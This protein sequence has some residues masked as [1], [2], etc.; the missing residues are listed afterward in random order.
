[1]LLVEDNPSI[2]QFMAMVVETHPIDL[3]LAGTLAE[4]GAALV[5]RAYDLVVTDL[6]L[7]DGDG[8]VRVADTGAKPDFSPFH[9]LLS[10]DADLAT[11]ECFAGQLEQNA[12]VLGGGRCGCRCG[13]SLQVL[14]S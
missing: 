5:A 10:V 1:M 11:T 2:Q 7:P 14:V 9:V 3:D 4:A 12:L 6:M 13:W 8:Q